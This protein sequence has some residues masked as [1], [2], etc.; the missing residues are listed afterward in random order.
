MNVELAVR[1]LDSV[2]VELSLDG[3]GDVEVYVPVIGS[4]CP[5]TG[6][7]IDRVLSVSG[8]TNHSTG[9]AEDLFVLLKY[10]ENDFLCE[11]KV[12]IVAD[13][14]GEV[15][16]ADILAAVVDN[17]GVSKRA[18]GKDNGSVV[19]GSDGGV[20]DTDVF[21]GTRNALSL[22]EFVELEGVGEDDKDTARK[23]GERTL[24]G[25]T[26]CNTYSRDNSRDAR[27]LDTEVTEHADN[28]KSLETV[29]EESDKDLCNHLVGALLF[30]GI[31]YLF[32]YLANDEEAYED[33]DD[34]KDNLQTF[35]GQ[36]VKKRGEEIFPVHSESLLSLVYFRII[37]YININTKTPKCQQ[38]KEI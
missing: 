38:K 24:N 20:D 6:N 30:A 32:A 35:G 8:H 4:V 22:D 26:Y 16:T 36:P 12:G 17:V 23:V 5:A 7:E 18:V 3:L 14:E 1:N 19:T 9:L 15:N 13:R 33:N 29:V 25:K 2:L 10:I 28:D 31:C 11:S 34:R 21:N 37:A 27:G